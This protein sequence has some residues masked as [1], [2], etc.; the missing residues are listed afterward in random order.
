MNTFTFQ[1]NEKYLNSKI[2]R[3]IQR[4]KSRKEW[5]LLLFQKKKRPFRQFSHDNQR[6]IM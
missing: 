5:I 6:E 2:N 3:N 4:R 1:S